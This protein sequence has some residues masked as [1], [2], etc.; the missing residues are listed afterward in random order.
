[1]TCLKIHREKEGRRGL[2]DRYRP[3]RQTLEGGSCEP[4]NARLQWVEGHFKPAGEP[5]HHPSLCSSELQ[6]DDRPLFAATG[7]V[8]LLCWPW[9]VI[10]L[11]HTLLLC[12][13]EG[14]ATPVLGFQTAHSGRSINSCQLEY[15]AM[16]KH[17]GCW[18]ETG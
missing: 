9:G 17:K 1:M 15:D 16:V 13:L 7:M 6:D 12:S 8:G 10:H 3:R 5:P 2:K 11:M 4:R 18:E 14:K